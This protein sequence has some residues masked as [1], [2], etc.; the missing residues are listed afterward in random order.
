M[1]AGRYAVPAVCLVYW[2]DDGFMSIWNM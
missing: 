1:L 2:P